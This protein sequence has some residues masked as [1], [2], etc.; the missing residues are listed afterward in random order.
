MNREVIRWADHFF[1]GHPMEMDEVLQRMSPYIRETTGTVIA[2]DSYMVAI[3]STIDPDD[4]FTEV[5]YIIKCTIIT[6]EKL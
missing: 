3:A 2:E 4:S 6:R 1:I 5:N